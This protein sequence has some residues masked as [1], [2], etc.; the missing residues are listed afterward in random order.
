MTP[1]SISVVLPAF[2][3]E[4]N[5]PLTVADAVEHLGRLTKTY[6]IV[7]V[8]DGSTDNTQAVAQSL[9]AGNRHVRLISHA[10]NRGY[11]A[12]VRSGFFAARCDLIFLTDADGQFSFEPLSDF[13]ECIETFDAVIG[14]RAHRADAWHRSLISAVGNWIARKSFKLRARDINCA[15]KLIRRD[16]LRTFSLKSHGA[17]ISAELLACATRAGCRVR[18][19]PVPHRSRAHGSATGARPA[20]IWRTV[21]EFIRL[22]REQRSNPRHCVAA[23]AALSGIA[24]AEDLPTA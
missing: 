16:A 18:E 21:V 6:E 14:R 8:N 13:L 24:I 3:E 11:G 1:H 17:M 9:C 19:L 22:W 7:V 10:S 5:L 15:F 20:V 23:D 2:N 12:A 4:E